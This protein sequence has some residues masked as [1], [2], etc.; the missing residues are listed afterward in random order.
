M[1]RLR[2]CVWGQRVYSHSPVWDSAWTE[3]MGGSV[4]VDVCGWGKRRLRNVLETLVFASYSRGW[5]GQWW[6]HRGRSARRGDRAGRE[7]RHR[8]EPGPSA[9]LGNWRFNAKRPMVNGFK[10]ISLPFLLSSLPWKVVNNFKPANFE[11]TF[12]PRRPA[13]FKKH[14]L[15]L[16]FFFP[17]GK[18][19]LSSSLYFH[20]LL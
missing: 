8:G 1:G 9:C 20:F 6:H 16:I 11:N 12:L 14:I 17:F 5:G 3:G 7:D 10:C 4:D 15:I 2:E 18:R 19:L 13:D